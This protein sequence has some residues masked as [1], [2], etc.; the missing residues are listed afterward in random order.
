MM[1]KMNV[2]IVEDSVGFAEW[3][4]QDL[5]VFDELEVSGKADSVKNAVQL[6]QQ[7][8][9]DIVVLDLWLNE[10]TGLDLLEILQGMKEMPA[11][12]VFSN[13]GLPVFKQKCQELGASGF[14][15]KSTEYFSLID[16]IRNYK[17]S[18]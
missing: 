11:V 7:N 12:F 10:G 4:K 13:Y 2:C 5:S 17:K 9:P 1:E 18:A 3:L 15:D 6:I 8:K 16:T 14:F